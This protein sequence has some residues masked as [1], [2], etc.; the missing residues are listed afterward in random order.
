[1]AFLEAKVP[2]DL[3]VPKAREESLVY[4]VS[5]VK[6]DP[7]VPSAPTDVA[8]RREDEDRMDSPENKVIPV[9]RDP[10]ALM[11][12]L[13]HREHLVT[14]E[15]LV[16]KDKLE[17]TAQMEKAV[18]LEALA[19]L[20]FKDQRVQR[21]QLVVLERGALGEKWDPKDHAVQPEPE[22]PLVCKAQW[23]S[24][25]ALVRM[26]NKATRV[27][28]ATAACLVFLA[29]RVW[30]ENR[31]ALDH[32]VPQETGAPKDL[33]VNWDLMERLVKR[34]PLDLLDREDLL[35]KMVVGV[36]LVNLV[37]LVL[38]DPQARTCTPVL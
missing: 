36:V 30:V 12:L 4:P 38:L 27:T 11:E 18:C 33:G 13:A 34:D 21:V 24:Q 22:E 17:R 28:Q 32:R 8:V 20:V 37:N 6:Q 23:E 29:L 1:M 19:S 10:M 7:R 9:H 15:H 14:T 3:P 26:V 2:Q 31:V 35:V 16:D 25:A 5:R